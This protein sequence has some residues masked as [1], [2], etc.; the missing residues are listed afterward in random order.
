MMRIALIGLIG[1]GFAFGAQAQD[2]SNDQAVGVDSTSD[3]AGCLYQAEMQGNPRD[4]CVGITAR[5][6][7]N[8]AV[9]TR[10]MINCVG[11]E[12][13]YWDARLNETYTELRNVYVTEDDDEPDGYIQLAPLLKT[14]QL[15]WIEWRDAKCKGF[16]TYRYRGGTLGRVT[17]ADCLMTMTAERVFELEDL[18]AEARM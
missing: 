5:P 4:G 11:V 10:D 13:D 7:L 16:E 14:T 1:L 9:S 17:A 3:M 18:L 6:C 12:T 15:A 2:A 8:E